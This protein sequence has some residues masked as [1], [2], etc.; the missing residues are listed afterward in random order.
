MILERRNIV[1]GI[2]LGDPGYAYERY[3]FTPIPT[4]S[5]QAHEAFNGSLITTRSFIERVFGRWEKKFPCLQ[6]VLRTMLDTSIATICATAVLW[7]IHVNLNRPTR[8]DLDNMD[9]YRDEALAEPPAP[10]KNVL[11]LDS[12]LSDWTFSFINMTEQLPDLEHISTSIFVGIRIIAYMVILGVRE[13][14]F[15]LEDFVGMQWSNDLET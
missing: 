6:G 7:N 12:T 3:S 2:L 15:M 4:P 10:D 11:D 9:I 5:N 13:R 8:W 14:H 1:K